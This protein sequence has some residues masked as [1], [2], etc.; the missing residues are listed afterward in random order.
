[1]T[2]KASCYNKLIFLVSLFFF[3]SP[4]H[5]KAV[6]SCQF[7]EV[8]LIVSSSQNCMHLGGNT[9]EKRHA[10]LAVYNNGFGL[11]KATQRDQ[12]PLVGM[13]TE[14]GVLGG[15]LVGAY[16]GI[17]VGDKIALR[18]WENSVL[19][20]GE[21][22][23]DLQ[24][25]AAYN[26]MLMENGMPAVENSIIPDVA[27][28]VGGVI[29]ASVGGA[30]MFAAGYELQSKTICKIHDVA[31]LIKVAKGCYDIGGKTV[32]DLK[33]SK[34]HKEPW[35][36]RGKTGFGLNRA[37]G[38]SLGSSAVV[39]SA[40]GVGGVVVGHRL[41]RPILCRIEKADFLIDGASKCAI[42][43]GKT[44]L[45]NRDISNYGR[46]LD[47]ADMRD[48]NP[49]EH[50]RNGA[51]GTAVGAVIGSRYKVT[52]DAL[53]EL[54][55]LELGGE[56]AETS[57]VEAGAVGGLAALA[58]LAVGYGLDKLVRCELS[59]NVF[60]VKTRNECSAISGQVIGLQA[61]SK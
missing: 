44:G 38:A 5:V 50:V 18:K 56:A 49:L 33:F 4:L 6:T 34:S 43:G 36:Y 9:L 14:T 51:L 48:M 20:P 30:L 45:L 32:T 55:E 26:T 42:V 19:D 47:K 23:A 52:K 28:G 7:G 15:V 35:A 59:G 12:S 39:G 2:T 61:Q 11:E 53:N 37:E 1:M 13:M 10:D 58:T 40:A 27:A 57:L 3:L 60:E 25:S 16:P 17:K 24:G 21:T 31:V 46:G 29:G 54:N 41:A 8:E 22:I